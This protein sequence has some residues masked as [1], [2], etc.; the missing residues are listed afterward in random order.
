MG[1]VYR[2]ENSTNT[3]LWDVDSP[4]EKPL[5]WIQVEAFVT[6][7]CAKECAKGFLI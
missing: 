2:K 4:I 3:I 7:I 6:M 1:N 5:L